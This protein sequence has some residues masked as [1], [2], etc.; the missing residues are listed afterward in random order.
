[1]G[2]CE[3]FPLC[4]LTSLPPFPSFLAQRTAYTRVDTRSSDSR[5]SSIFHLGL[6]PALTRESPNTRPIPLS[7]EFDLPLD[8]RCVPW[9]WHWDKCADGRCRSAI[10][11]AF[12]LHRSILSGSGDWPGD[13]TTMKNQLWVVYKIT[14][15]GNPDGMNAVCEQ[16]EWDAM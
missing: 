3:R 7:A 16:S 13:P 5:A 8:D 4:L 1:Q 10:S 11:G 9:R 2:S 15:R 14:I 6:F 12:W